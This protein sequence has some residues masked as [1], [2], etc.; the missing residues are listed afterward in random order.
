MKKIV[1][2]VLAVC[3][4]LLAVGLFI[5][6]RDEPLTPLAAQALNYQPAPVPA[7]QNAYV[8]MM[9]L[10]APAG[11][12][13][14]RVGE[15]RIQQVNWQQNAKQE[16]ENLVFSAK[17]Y[18]FACAREI[19]ENC[20]DEILAD[21]K[22]IQKLAQENNEL[23][24]R[25]LK[26]LEMP[27]FSNNSMDS[28]SENFIGLNSE[29]GNISRLLSAKAVLDI[30]HGDIAIGLRGIEK[31]MTFYR[32]VLVAKEAVLIDKMIAI[33]HLRRY[34][35]L[36]S[37]LI[38]EG[39]L[40]GQ[41]EI[42]RA[43]LIPLDSHKEIFKDATWRERVGAVQ[44]MSKMMLNN[45]PGKLFDTVSLEDGQVEAADFFGKL[46]GYFNY[47]FLYKH[48]M[49]ANL[50]MEL[51]QY[52]M[53]IIDATPLARLPSANIEQQALERAGCTKKSN[54]APVVF[55]KDAPLLVNDDL[56]VPLCNHPKNYI[57]EVLA[58]IGEPV[59]TDYLLRIYDADAYLRLVRAQLE[60]QLAAKQAGTTPAEILASLP[61]ETFNPYTEKAFDVD[62]TQGII[63]FQPADSRYTGKRGEIR[64]SPPKP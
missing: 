20:L 30:K 10:T 14:I 47:Y 35:I 51:W 60:Y 54:L 13:F 40:Q 4:A 48:N 49:T 36:L 31:D 52:E 33:M 16:G 9:G 26:I 2:V 57:G 32:R 39:G 23:I 8:G 37:L 25:Y 27:L 59:Y 38:G 56:L 12:D 61:P 24:Q 58:L 21:A 46:H 17:D 22:N 28:M 41:D 55:G 50:Q 63:S 45:S 1:L 43:L 3:M 7:E 64:I 19:T 6:L 11:S 62:A 34:A 18:T 42:V 29:S 15:A 44:G 5:V 53:E